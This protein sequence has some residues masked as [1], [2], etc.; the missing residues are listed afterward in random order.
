MP[1]DVEGVIP[2]AFV[3]TYYYIE[4]LQITEKI[5]T[6]LNQSRPEWLERRRERSINAFTKKWFNPETGDFCG[7][8]GASN[9]FALNLGLGNEKTKE[10]LVRRYERL[11]KMDTGIFGTPVLLERLF[12]EGEAEL[13]FRLMTSKSDVSY[14]HM[15]AAGA[16]TLWE[17]W[18]GKESH[19]HPMFGSV[20]KLLFTEILGIRQSEESVGY[21]NYEIR[22]ADIPQITWAKGKIE[23]V[24]GV[25]EVN[26]RRDEQGEVKI[27]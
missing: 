24:N 13:A 23:T 12:E 26:W 22:P 17:R 7:G 16:T 4:G 2:P 3:N 25:I 8:I 20:A 1:E 14:Y 6:L 10:N 19:D 27:L 9:A 5:A 21:R 15:M 18:D 11:G